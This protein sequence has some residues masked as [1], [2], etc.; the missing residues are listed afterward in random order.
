[1]IFLVI[2]CA[3]SD[4]AF[5]LWVIKNKHVAVYF[6]TVKPSKDR[7][8]G[9][10]KKGR[11]E[12]PGGTD[13]TLEMQASEDHTLAIEDDQDHTPVKLGVNTSGLE[14]MEDDSE[15]QMDSTGENLDERDYKQA[16]VVDRIHNFASLVMPPSGYRA[17]QD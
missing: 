9:R 2:I 8:F 1:M 13:H 14:E 11:L 12:N 10:R 16:T 7:K 4:L 15:D 17:V 5:Q 6:Q 3:L